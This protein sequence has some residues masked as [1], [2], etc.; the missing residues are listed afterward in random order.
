MIGIAADVGV[1]RCDDDDGGEGF[2]GEES[3]RDGRLVID[4]C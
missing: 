2:S 4:A 1:F 3:K